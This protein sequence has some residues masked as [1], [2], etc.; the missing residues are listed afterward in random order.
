MN[1]IA[2]TS[3][4]LQAARYRKG[5]AVLELEFRNGAV[6]HYLSVPA[7]TFTELLDAKSKGRYFNLHIRNEFPFDRIHPA[8]PRETFSRRIS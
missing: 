8:A 7:G 6:Y 1:W 3:Q 5:D 4:S 2:L